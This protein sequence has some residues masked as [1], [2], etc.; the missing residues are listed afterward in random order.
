MD[1]EDYPGSV[2]EAFRVLRSGGELLMSIPHPCFSAPVSG[3]QHDADGQRSHF[4]GCG[5]VR[6]SARLRIAIWPP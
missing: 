6:A 4:A 3:S 1:V 2:R 5:Y